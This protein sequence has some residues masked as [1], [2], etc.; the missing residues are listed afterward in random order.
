MTPRQFFSLVKRMKLRERNENYR[1]AMIC[2]VIVNVNKSKG[3]KVKPG[4]FLG[5]GSGG[6][7]SRRNDTWQKQLS[8][9]EALNVAFGGKDLRGKKGG[10]S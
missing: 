2:S 4:D 5:E 9:V 3:R 7:R 10:S 6:K 8:F 1:M